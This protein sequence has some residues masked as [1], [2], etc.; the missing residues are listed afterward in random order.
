M[1]SKNSKSLYVAALA[2]FLLGVGA[3]M[4]FGLSEN[5]I[6]FLN[7]AEALELPQEEQH[8]ARLFGTV[9]AEGLALFQGGAG[10][11]FL[12][13]DK[14]TAG[15]TLWVVYRGA[16]PDAF[17]AGAEVIVEG[18]YKGA[19]AEF[20]AEKLMTQCPSKYQKENRG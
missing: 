18:V 4:A 12:L 7:V 15:K 10:V 5:R 6:Y 9:S 2:F 13:Q 20:N 19:H 11:K 16:V 14:D 17:K 1:A 8:S 3:L